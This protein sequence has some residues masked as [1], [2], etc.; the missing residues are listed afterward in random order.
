MLQTGLQGKVALITG[1]NHGIGAATARAL[2]AEGCHVLINYLRLPLQGITEN[3]YLAQ[4]QTETPGIALYNRKRRADAANVV[5]EIRTQGGKADAIEADLADPATI[6]ML[7]EEAEKRFGTVDILVN[8]ADHCEQ[9]TFLAQPG[10][11][12]DG[13]PNA[14]ITAALH[15]S[16]FAVNSRAVALLMAEFASRHIAA[17]KQWGRIINISTDGAPGFAGEVSYGASKA[18]LESYSRAAAQELGPYGITVNIVSPGP[19]QTG[20]ISPQ[21]VAEISRVTPLRRVGQPDDI[22][23][24]IVFLASEQARWLTGQLLSV[25]GGLRMP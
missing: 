3:D 11:A 7:F 23:D 20:W 8:N 13:F 18:A 24:V 17:R 25:S 5:Q 21:Q 12:A 19:I 6:P 4:I 9:D 1:G 14:T 10:L 22:A 15:D 2:A 16:H